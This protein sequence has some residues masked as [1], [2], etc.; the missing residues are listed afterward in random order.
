MHLFWRLSSGYSCSICSYTHTRT[1]LHT[2]TTLTPHVYKQTYNYTQIW[3]PRPS[4]NHRKPPRLRRQRARCSPFVA[5]RVRGK[6]LESIQAETI[7][8]GTTVPGGKIT[9]SSALEPWPAASTPG[10]LAT[11]ATARSRDRN[12]RAWLYVASATNNQSSRRVE[13]TGACM[14]TRRNCWCHPA[15]KVFET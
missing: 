3:R 1:T 6:R 2:H 12:L 5:P 10:G 11:R 13:R 9:S 14:H 8:Q 4:G 15:C 7:Q